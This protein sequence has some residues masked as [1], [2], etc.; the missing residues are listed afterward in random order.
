[1][2]KQQLVT[3]FISEAKDILDTVE[4]S[5]IEVEKLPSLQDFAHHEYV[6]K[7][8]RGF[9]TL[10]GT[11]GLL[12]LQN[13]VKVSHNAETL[14]DLIR[15]NKT[16]PNANFINTLLKTNDFLRR[17]LGQYEISQTDSGLEEEMDV[18]LQELKS[19]TD[20]IGFGLT[21][22]EEVQPTQE[23]FGFFED[24]Q[25]EEKFGFFEDDISIED[26][27]VNMETDAS[28]ESKYES[29]QHGNIKISSEKLDLLMDLT[30]ELVI[31]ELSVS[32]HPDL[33]KPELYSLRRNVQHLNKIVRDVQ[34]VVLST[35]MIP[36]ASVF[37]RIPRLVRDLALQ[38][39]KEVK[40][41]VLGEETEIDKS[42]VDLLLDPIIHIIRNAIDHGIEPPNERLQKGKSEHGNIL[43]QASQ[44]A[45]EVKI[46][47]KDDGRGINKSKV[48]EKALKNNLID[49][50]NK[51]YSDKEIYEFIFMPGFSTSEKITDVSGRGV[52][53]DIVRQGV[54][55]INGRIDVQSTEGKGTSFII[56]MPLTLGIMD[57]TNIR[58]G[59]TYITLQRI[60]I[61]EIVSMI[62]VS[63]I[64][65]ENGL[66]VIEVRGKY[67]PLLKLN[68]ILNIPTRI[69]Y[70]N[71]KQL[72][73]ILEY[74]E[75]VLGLLVDQVVSNQSVVVK[76]LQG[77]LLE[78]TKGINGFTILGNGNISLIL[79][80]KTIFEKYGMTQVK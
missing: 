29:K 24:E 23:K 30:G 11:S 7:L 59:Q 18:L 64:L 33:S 49:K 74:E 6:H 34:E 27:K 8:F 15:K 36:M 62:D 63:P 25:E 46:A 48:L 1:M 39:G 77:E 22:K 37:A 26:Q 17:L 31:A 2:D 69:N 75:E 19:R 66:K 71:A 14:L 52:G 79:D 3:E 38:L 13:M 9:H 57:G 50:Q 5:L 4:N 61:R 65:L 12:K 40:L 32:Y 45:N 41:Q 78:K 58:V 35:R 55:K 20:E 16:L 67:I 47:I 44:S 80:T 51:D 60:E 54:Q 68:D 53:M 28:L 70:D 76:P 21:I 56:R 73:I 72:T 10:K 43:I 42:L